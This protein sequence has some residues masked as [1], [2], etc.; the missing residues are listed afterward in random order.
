[1][2]A[3]VSENSISSYDSCSFHDPPGR[4]VQRP[5]HDHDELDVQFVP[6]R[7][8][9]ARFVAYERRV[10]LCVCKE[11]TETFITLVTVVQ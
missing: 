11:R 9:P 3:R 4:D 6:L 8:V 7:V 5:V 1:M 10:L 2:D